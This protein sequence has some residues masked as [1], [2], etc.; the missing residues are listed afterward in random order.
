MTIR[1]AQTISGPRW[2]VHVREDQTTNRKPYRTL[3][4]RSRVDAEAF[5]SRRQ[6][7][8]AELGAVWMALSAA[9]RSQLIEAYT[10]AKAGGYTLA[11]ACD[12]MATRVKSPTI[13]DAIAEYTESRKVRGLRVRSMQSIR[14]A[15]TPLQ[16]EKGA[17]L[18]AQI[19][20][21]DIERILESRWPGAVSRATALRQMAAF[22]AWCLRRQYS[23][24]NPAAVIDKPVV[25]VTRP[26]ILTIHEAERLMRTT[27]ETDPEMVGYMAICLFAGLRP[28]S[29]LMRLTRD[30]INLS[31]RFIEILPR[32]KTRSRRLVTIRDNLHAWLAQWWGRGVDPCPQHLRDRWREIRAKAGWSA[33]AW[34]R[35]CMRHSWVSYSYALLGEVE[36]AMQA[37]HSAS[38][39]HQHYRELVT[40]EDAERYF[41]ILPANKTEMGRTA[42]VPPSAQ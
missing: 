26:R 32:A 18:V 31:R 17:V 6:S 37:G 14:Y 4:F 7:E 15:L 10:R 20:P 24:R 35:D 28:E 29:E 12:A 8:K 34:P 3:S 19:Q 5:V 38:V 22:F 9:E 41:A 27:E 1:K 39:L 36:T 2:L 40:R 13:A 21:A 33:E 42:V 16:R 25:E 30:E 11:Q 23:P